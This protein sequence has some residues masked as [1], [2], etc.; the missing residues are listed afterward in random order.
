MS[1]LNAQLVEYK[2]I[3]PQVRHFVFQVPE[4]DRLDY[5][6]GQFVSLTDDVSG[7]PITRAYSVCSA[8][9]SNRFELCLNLVNEGTFTPHLFHLRPGD[10]VP[11]QGPL[12][13]FTLR[14]PV[15]D[16]VFVATGTG[17]APFRSMF[18]SPRLWSSGRRLTLIFGVRYEQGILYRDDFERFEKEHPSFRFWPVLSRPADGWRGRTGH[19][20]HHVLEAV[21]ERRDLDVYI[22]GLKAMVDDVR[23]LLKGVGFDRKRLVYEKY[24]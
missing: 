19:V 16:S 20:Q 17:I 3:A 10:I 7:R 18:Q 4:V 11:I 6:P 9:C 8:P 23:K 2:D 12:G 21:G 14:D 22:C 5:Q 13:Y 1:H 15:T 24:D